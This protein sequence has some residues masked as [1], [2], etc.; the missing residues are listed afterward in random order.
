M[1][2]LIEQKELE[3]SFLLLLFVYLLLLF[4]VMCTSS[5]NQARG[6]IGDFTKAPGV[7]VG[8]GAVVGVGVGVGVGGG[9][10]QTIEVRNTEVRP[11]LSLLFSQLAKCVVYLWIS[12][13]VYVIFLSQSLLFS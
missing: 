4:H 7:G 9:M 13:L 5:T 12:F 3:V 2:Q 6:L 11:F 1:L 8:V 10:P